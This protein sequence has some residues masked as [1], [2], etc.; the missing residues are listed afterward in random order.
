MT[1]DDVNIDDVSPI[2]KQPIKRKTSEV[3]DDT[4]AAVEED[5]EAKRVKVDGG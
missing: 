1:N 5:T 4:T 3:E 2:A